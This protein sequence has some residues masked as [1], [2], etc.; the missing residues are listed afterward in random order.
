MGHREVSALDKNRRAICHPSCNYETVS[1]TAKS[2]A[3]LGLFVRDRETP[4]R[5][6]MRGGGGSQLATCLLPAICGFAGSF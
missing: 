5:T 4:V 3:K 1:R 6:G 2:P